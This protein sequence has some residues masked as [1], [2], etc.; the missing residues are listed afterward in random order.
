M[1]IEFGITR[2]E[3]AGPSIYHKVL[4]L[5]KEVLTD[6][7]KKEGLKKAGYLNDNFNNVNFYMQRAVLKKLGYKI[8]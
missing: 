2:I 6:E 1:K 4:Y 3:N 7:Q 5:W 8:I